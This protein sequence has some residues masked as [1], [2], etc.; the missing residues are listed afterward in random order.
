MKKTDVCVSNQGSTVGHLFLR[1]IRETGL[2]SYRFLKSTNLPDNEPNS[3][4]NMHI[5]A[6]DESY[7]IIHKAMPHS[8]VICTVFCAQ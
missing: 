6:R 8:T 4:C 1:L 7:E 2:N 3:F 5:H